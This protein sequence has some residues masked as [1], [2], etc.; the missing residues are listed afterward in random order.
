VVGMKRKMNI[1][2]GGDWMKDLDIEEI[3]TLLELVRNEINQSNQYIKLYGNMI[4]D[5]VVRL[6]N[7]N[8]NNLMLMEYKLENMK[9][10]LEKNTQA[11]CLDGHIEI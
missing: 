10:D 5:S 7:G 11:E 2:K 9:K 4:T 1:K 8:I 6:L 3:K